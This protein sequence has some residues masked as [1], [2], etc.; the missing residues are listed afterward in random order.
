MD[1]LS[2]LGIL[3]D[4]LG[5]TGLVF[6][7]V[8]GATASLLAIVVGVLN[9][10]LRRWLSAGVMSLLWAMVLVRLLV[11]L[12]PPSMVSLQNLLR[13]IPDADAQPPMPSSV[14]SPADDTLVGA[15][16][17]EA[18][19]T[20][21]TAPTTVEAA[22]SVHEPTPVLDLIA[23]LL[24]AAWLVGLIALLAAT[25]VANWRFHRLLGQALPCTDPPLLALWNE[26][27][28][29]VGC[30]RAI[31]L[32]H[33]ETIDHVAVA[34]LWRPKL[35]LPPAALDLSD[36]ELRMVMLHELGHV[37]RYDIAAN[38]LLALVRAAHWWNPVYWLAAARFRALREQ[39]CDAF[40]L[41][42]LEG[43][44]A[45]AY[46]E[47]L[48]KLLSRPAMHSR[49]R[50]MLPALI[51]GF[52]SG[53]V[54]RRAA[55]NRLQALQRAGVV[56]GR[57]QAI[58]A[59][60][61]VALVAIAGL[62][63]AQTPPPKPAPKNDWLPGAAYDWDVWASPKPD[64]GPEIARTYDL[65]KIWE[66]IDTNP[67]SDT[68]RRNVYW[69]LA[70][71]LPMSASQHDVKTKEWADERMKL[72]GDRLTIT[73]PRTVNDEIARLLAAW[74][75]SGI[76]Q[77]CIETRFLTCDEDVAARLGVAWRYV[78][79]VPP[80]EDEEAFSE[81]REEKLNVRAAASVDDYLATA[82]ATLDKQ[83]A[84]ALVNSIIANV[85][86]QTLQAPK[87]TAFNGQQIFLNDYTQAAYTVGIARLADGGQRPR[88]VV[89]DEGVKIKMRTLQSAD[90]K[91]IGLDGHIDL[92]KI[93]EVRKITAVTPD[94][95]T[96]LEIPRVRHC[97]IDVS[98]TL[99]DGQSLLI[100]CIP[101]YEQKQFLY[102][103]L[104]P[105][106]IV[107]GDGETEAK[108]EEQ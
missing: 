30:R 22:S 50:I 49:W 76:G 2:S 40:A 100:G 32:L 92:S 86:G 65:A 36:D 13:M 102:L 27:R 47:L 88:V 71:V 6:S 33:L 54:R 108:R 37:R 17:D 99:A 104:T 53:F 1:G 60:L 8:A 45:R 10:A 74:E 26:C 7:I 63:D 90:A 43:C 79:P 85:T 52:L 42:H 20:L 62:T 46:S 3:L 96:T 31:P 77:T 70:H 64:P 106:V 89:V 94:G 66:R 9:V 81:W 67:G 58:G 4:D 28:R 34:G 11:P 107:E 24:P 80:A 97:Q 25:L 84:K 87:V 38:W 61:V 59:A 72:D 29:L 105:K 55:Q 19:A 68:A 91:T 83:Q 101:T 12:A 23:I 14:A 95:P 56:R 75:K 51:V 78:G 41:A 21:A 48:L 103:L 69:L 93:E 39:A 73:A 44:P 82:V 16:A 18:A 15:E 57:W 35:L 5:S 98:S